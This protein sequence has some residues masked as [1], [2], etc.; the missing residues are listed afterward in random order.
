MSQILIGLCRNFTH[1]GSVFVSMTMLHFLESFQ[2]YCSCWFLSK[3]SFRIFDLISEIDKSSA[4]FRFLIL[5]IS[6]ITVLILML[7][8]LVCAG[9][10]QP[11]SYHSPSSA[12][13]AASPRPRDS[14]A[15]DV[16]VKLLSCLQPFRNRCTRAAT[17]RF[18]LEIG[19]SAEPSARL[20]PPSAWSRLKGWRVAHNIKCSGRCNYLIP[21]NWQPP[22]R[23]AAELSAAGT[24]PVAPE[25]GRS[26]WAWGLLH[27]MLS[28]S[29]T[30]HLP[31]VA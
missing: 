22:R 28:S 1:L 30:S 24:D 13:C 6:W 21:P 19:H 12:V 4:A 7:T 9:V 2:E 25:V 11:G 8:A 27:N 16:T 31:T 14:A 10:L 20:G 17:G 3:F 5:I 18:G 15:S 29:V 23:A 26:S